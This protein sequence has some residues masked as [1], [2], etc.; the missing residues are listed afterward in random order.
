MV[1][2]KTAYEAQETLKTTFMLSRVTGFKT[3]G[4]RGKTF[5]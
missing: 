3:T 4:R 5:L 1:E 2:K